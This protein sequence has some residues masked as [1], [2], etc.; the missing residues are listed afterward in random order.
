MLSEKANSQKQIK[1][2]AIGIK[3]IQH[4]MKCQQ[5]ALLAIVGMAPYLRLETLAGYFPRGLS[6]G[7]RGGFRGL[8]I[9]MNPSKADISVCRTWIRL[10]LQ[11]QQAAQP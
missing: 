10:C 4:K 9:K 6:E 1:K 7:L 8:S 3:K 5:W 11:S 2:P